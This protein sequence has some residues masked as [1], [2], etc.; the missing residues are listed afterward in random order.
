MNQPSI[1]KGLT[2]AQIRKA[3]YGGHKPVAEV[4]R[5]KPK[6]KKP[7][8]VVREVQTQDTGML[9]NM[10]FSTT[11]TASQYKTP[12]WFTS[13]QKADVSV[14]V[15]L[16]GNS[17]QNL[18]RSWDRTNG[19]MRVEVIFVDD[20][21][22][23]N[24]KDMAL[25][26][27]EEGK[28]VKGRI[29]A[30]AFRQGWGACCNIGAEKATGDILVFAHP[31]TALTD[32]WLRP[33]VRL[34]RKSDVGA[35]GPLVLDQDGRTFA[36]AGGEWLWDSQTFAD[37]G[38]SVYKGGRISK[39]FTIDNTPADL[40]EAGETD[41]VDGRCLAVRRADF[42]YHGGFSPNLTTPEWADADLCLSLRERGMKTL[43]QRSAHVIRGVS[44]E[45]DRDLEMGKVFFRNKWV[46]NGRIDPLV[47]PRP[48]PRAEI[49]NIVIR[50]R[51]AHGDV[52][53]AAAV[54]PALKKKHPKAKIVFST[55][56]PEVVEGNPWIDKVVE[57][58]SERWFQFYCDLDMVYEY[59]PGTNLLTA[60]A[61]AVGVDPKDCEP[62]LATAPVDAL[63][64]KY[65]V[66]HA[67]KT[68]WVGRNWTTLK[69]DSISNRLRAAGYK[70]VCV[71]T[72][73]DHKT[74]ACDLD[75]RDKTTVGQLA[76][77]V[78][79]AKV[80]VGID[81]FPMHVAQTFKVPGV[82]FFGAVNPASRLV[83]DHIKPVV[84]DGVKC[85][86]C[87]HRKPTPCTSTTTCDVGVQDCVNNVSAEQMWRT[88]A[89][90][91]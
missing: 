23:V 20:G 14:I 41:R 52:L 55:D 27:C 31:D 73:S 70:V 34:L 69:F 32:G 24:S 15:P 43:C 35:V 5:H 18:I 48:A 7:E 90:M 4:A 44:P 61:E 29:Y 37:T 33:L 71:G 46:V 53:M 47:G 38:R 68:M 1:S 6:N 49:E 81:S 87:H 74:T 26:E 57:V 83:G 51:A 80:F 86:G 58:H 30:S 64:E 75:L 10:P 42:L 16:Y 63:P 3:V 56:C 88:I 62:Y 9:L 76:T 8:K 82:C 66:V 40:L 39:P 45:R 21:C 25:R 60:Y 54:A 13:T 79:G 78:R 89:P 77:V 59:R 2:P 19:G 72:W 84:A 67:G 22:P 85:L 91:L 11:S 50:R 28:T 12:E 17:A 36:G 65:A